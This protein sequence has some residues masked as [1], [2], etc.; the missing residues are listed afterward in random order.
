MARHDDE[1]NY[2]YL[3]V[4]NDNTVSLRRLI[5]GGITVLDSAALPVT[6]NTWYDLRLEVIGTSLRGYV[7][8]RMLLEATD[9][10]FAV[11]SYGIA[12]YKAAVH[13]DD[14]NVTQP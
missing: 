1:N 2:Y 10:T 7:N 5:N 3:T 4:R 9:D 11:G 6:V 14:F 8:G 13:V 12:M